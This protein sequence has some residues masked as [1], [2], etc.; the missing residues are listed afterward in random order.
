M[1]RILAALL[2]RGQPWRSAARS[3]QAQLILLSS[4]QAEQQHPYR[5]ADAHRRM[6]VAP[7]ALAH[8][9]SSTGISHQ[10]LA[11]GRQAVR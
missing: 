5:P 6:L 2:F 8:T 11:A 9:A 7:A 1:R 10:S 4:H 3:S